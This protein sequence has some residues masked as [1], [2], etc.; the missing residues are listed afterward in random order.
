MVDEVVSQR[1]LRKIPLWW[2]LW[3]SAATGDDGIGLGMSI[4]M[5]V[6][7]QPT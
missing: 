4:T 3:S 6:G 7:L 1:C 5:E 2:I